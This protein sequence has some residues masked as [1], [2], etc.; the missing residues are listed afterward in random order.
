MPH[1]TGNWLASWWSS[2]DVLAS[3]GYNFSGNLAVESHVFVTVLNLLVLVV[4]WM[5]I[6]DIFPAS[7]SGR[8]DGAVAHAARP[9]RMQASMRSN[10]THTHNVKRKACTNPF[11][12]PNP[13]SGLQDSK[14]VFI[15]AF[16]TKVPILFA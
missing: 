10:I 5:L 6:E 11:T 12:Y 3:K 15:H 7:C 1:P 14:P 4:M 13:H 2:D 16:C 9:F 8:A